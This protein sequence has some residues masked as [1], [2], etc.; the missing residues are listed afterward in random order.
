MEKSATT[1]FEA[2]NELLNLKSKLE[3]RRKFK[4]VPRDSQDS[5]ASKIDH[6]APLGEFV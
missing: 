4:F 1:S 2:A 3:N 5:E 6:T